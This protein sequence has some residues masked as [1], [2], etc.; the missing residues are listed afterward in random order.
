MS[1]K[2]AAK[3]RGALAKEPVQM[4]ETEPTVLS[5][6]GAQSGAAQREAQRVAAMRAAS[7]SAQR[8]RAADEAPMPLPQM[9]VPEVPRWLADT[10]RVL[11]M[12]LILVGS[13]KIR[14]L[15]VHNYGKVIHEFDP[16]FNYR[17]VRLHS[18]RAALHQAA[19]SG[20]LTRVRDRA[21]HVALR[22]LS[23]CRSMAM[24]SFRH[25]LT[26]RSGTRSDDRSAR[27]PTRACC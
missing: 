3:R 9:E 19:W 1:T 4:A 6:S 26:R 7:A 13:Y 8:L 16:W 14:L 5:R 20:T 10:V 15:A 27:Q 11:L 18:I 22:R 21:S 17:A 2:K 24:R 23:T 12:A 25:G